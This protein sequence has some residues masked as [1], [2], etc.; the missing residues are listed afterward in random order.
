MLGKAV[1]HE[2][3]SFNEFSD[4][5]FCMDWSSGESHRDMKDSQGN[6]YKVCEQ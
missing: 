3:C 5:R 4:V 1:K 2:I 6:W